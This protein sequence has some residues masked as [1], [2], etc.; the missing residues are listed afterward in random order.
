MHEIRKDPFQSPVLEF[1]INSRLELHPPFSTAFGKLLDAAPF[2]TWPDLDS[3]A[4]LL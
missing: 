4:L 3:L 1:V 2:W